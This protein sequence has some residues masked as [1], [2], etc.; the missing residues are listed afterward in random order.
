MWTLK[1]ITTTP[2]A[3]ELYITFTEPDVDIIIPNY[4]YKERTLVF[5]NKIP[6]EL[7]SCINNSS[8][9][10]DGY[11]ASFNCV[12]NFLKGQL[13]REDMLIIQQWLYTRV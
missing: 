7:V 12:M 10:I 1:S 13:T 9:T 4:N 2:V 6:E 3:D 8:P 11:S 5:A